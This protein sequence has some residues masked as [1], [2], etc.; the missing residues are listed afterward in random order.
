MK[1]NMSRRV[2]LGAAIV[3]PVVAMVPLLKPKSRPRVFLAKPIPKPSVFFSVLEVDP[4]TAECLLY[5]KH[6]NGRVGRLIDRMDNF[7]KENKAIGTK[8]IGWQTEELDRAGC[9]TWRNEDTGAMV[10]Q[11]MIDDL[12]CGI[13]SD[14]D[15][16]AYTVFYNKVH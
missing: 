13:E 8:P 11:E 15:K 16:R 6:M 14:P 1:L 12:R 3:A 4:A 5:F 9:R 2:L 7:K 10:T